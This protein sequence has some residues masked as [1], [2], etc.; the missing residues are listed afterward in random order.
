MKKEKKVL[1]REKKSK[2]EPNYKC[3]N[4]QALNSASVKANLKLII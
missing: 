1:V 2:T 4:K 3:L